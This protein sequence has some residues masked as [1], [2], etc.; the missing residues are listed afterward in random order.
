MIGQV[1]TFWCSG[2]VKNVDGEDVMF[3]HRQFALNVAKR[4]HFQP[5]GQ[6]LDITRWTKRRFMLCVVRKR[7]RAWRKTLLDVWCLG[8]QIQQVLS[9]ATLAQMRSPSYVVWRGHQHDD[10]CLTCAHDRT[11]RYV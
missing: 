5:S 1:T 2:Y 6:I 10:L 7:Q 3:S 9:Y 11:S 8:S 4:G